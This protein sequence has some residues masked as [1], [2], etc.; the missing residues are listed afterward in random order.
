M[1]LA[2]K[3]VVTNSDGTL[4]YREEHEWTN[5]SADT[6][7]FFKSKLAH[8]ESFAKDNHGKHEDGAN[9]TANLTATLDGN[10]IAAHSFTGVSYKALSKF[11]REAHKIGD[12]L[13]KLGEEKAKHKK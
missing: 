5:L 8:L 7:N 9:L 13:I 11:E 6:L 10:Q 1:N 2:L 3:A 12:E 4:F